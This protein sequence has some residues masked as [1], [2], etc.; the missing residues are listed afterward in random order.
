MIISYLWVK[1]YKN[2]INQGF[3]FDDRISYTFELTDKLLIYANERDFIKDFFPQNISVYAVIGENGAGKTTL[4]NCLASILGGDIFFE[5]VIIFRTEN[6]F[7]VYNHGLELQIGF[8]DIFEFEEIH[9]INKLPISAILYSNVKATNTGHI[10]KNV[11][12]LTESYLAKCSKWDCDYH[13]GDEISELDAHELNDI[14]RQISYFSNENI[15]SLQISIPDSLHFSISM[16]YERV[17][18]HGILSDYLIYYIGEAETHSLRFSINQNVSKSFLATML[19]CFLREV[20]EKVTRSGQESIAHDKVYKELSTILLKDVFDEKETIELFKKFSDKRYLQELFNED[21][22][23]IQSEIISI[24]ESFKNKIIFY[25]WL[26]ENNIASNFLSL[27]DTSKVKEFIKLYIESI[28]KYQYLTIGWE[29]LSSGENAKLNFY[30][31][32]YERIHN[33][34]KTLSEN[35]VLHKVMY[36]LIDEGATFF[37][38]EWQR[39]FIHDILLFISE[40]IQRTS[41]VETVQII[42]TSHSPF[43]ISDLTRNHI[44]YLQKKTNNDSSFGFCEVL[45]DSEKPLSFAGNINSLYRNSFF[46]KEA[47][48]GKFSETKISEIIELIN[49][50]NIKTK[51]TKILIE[52]I[53]EPII[54]NHILKLLK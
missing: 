40:L 54:R 37:H 27:K 28:Y 35:F 20:F 53:S 32:I 44:I 1:N 30:S 34:L 25:N 14:A 39:T 15:N 18:H 10:N 47:L 41:K 12:L 46:L 7:L 6:K 33:K 43:V 49:N 29:G 5:T 50:N 8:D 21:K 36:L 52:E 13:Y 16:A 2:I 51:N 42:L 9:D 31:R 45:S 38:P 24:S 3:S 22:L 17:I 26:T 4:L 23:F 19:L 11:S 48:I